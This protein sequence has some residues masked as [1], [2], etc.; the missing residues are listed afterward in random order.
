M[1]LTTLFLIGLGFF[2]AP[3]LIKIKN[4]S[5]SDQYGP[6]SD[7]V[8]TKIKKVLGKSLPEAS[9]NISQIL[10]DDVL[11]SSFR[12]QFM[13]PDKLAVN[14]VVRKP[15][16]ALKN[17]SQPQSALVGKN[18]VVVAVV[19]STNLPTL[20]IPT[21]IP[22]VGEQVSDRQFFAL[23]ILNGMFYLYQTTEGEI[24][25]DSLVTTDPSGVK[26][27]FPLSGDKDVLLGSARL[28]LSR[29]NERKEDSRIKNVGIIDLRF[30]NP[31]LK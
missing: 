5:C 14:L 2:V 17:A 4:V 9:E 22:N 15:A 18:K 30:K 25:G 21:N 29:L 28:I 11:I 10:K 6:C 12:T 19:P 20:N 8:D 23:E 7:A 3:R 1:P 27:I 26:I 16:F 24:Q 13:L 31:V